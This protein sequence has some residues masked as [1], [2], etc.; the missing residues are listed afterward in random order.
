MTPDRKVAQQRKPAA[1]TRSTWIKRSLL[2][3]PLVSAGAIMTLPVHSAKAVPAFAEQTGLPCSACHVGG[4]GPQLTPFGREFKLDGYTLRAQK[5]VPLAAMAVA[6]LTHTKRDQV[7]A[8][9]GLDQNDNVAFDQG[10]IFIAGGLGKHFGMFSQTTYDGVGQ[11]WA[12]DNTDIRAVTKANLFGADTT[13]GLTLNNSPTVQDA[14]NTTPAWGFPY[15]DT[16][17]SGTP[18]AAPLIDDGLATES[19]GLSAYAWIGQKF[20]LEGGAYTTPAAGTLNWLGADPS[21]GPGN[22]HGLAPY[23]RVAWQ[24]NAGGG[25]LELGAFVLNANVYPDRDMS[26][27]FTDHYTDLGFDASWQKQLASGDVLSAQARYVHENANYRASCALGMIGPMTGP[28][29]ASVGLNELRGDFG[30]HW[31][32]KLGATIGAFSITGDSNSALYDSSTASPDSNGVMLQLDYSPWGD[33]NGPL[34][35]RVNLQLGLQAT[36]YGKFNGA[37]TNYDG[38]G[39]NASDNNAVRVYSW[40]AF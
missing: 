5:S 33:G 22:I 3:L 6:S 31:H 30:Y 8:P 35:K 38:A 10:S 4:F 23:G 24:G 21:G 37:S 26:S 16:A 29:C 32:N 39:A 7:P 28:D 20:Y 11:A 12:W 19:V 13:L 9:D 27:G 36:F 18:D 25:T 14:W 1:S 40:L 34:G 17:V 15:T 2:L